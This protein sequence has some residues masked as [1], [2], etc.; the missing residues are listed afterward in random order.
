M[1][2]YPCEF[3]AAILSNSPMGY[4]PP[5]T[6]CVEARRR[7]VGI[8]RPC[9]NES[10]GCFK[11]E[12]KT[13]RVSLRQVKGMQE[14]TLGRIL[15]EREKRLFE[16]LRDFCARVRP[17][18]HVLQNLILAGALDSFSTNRRELLWEVDRDV[19][20]E[21]QRENAPQERFAVTGPLSSLSQAES[22]VA[23]FTPAERI[24][25]EYEVL[26]IN[27]SSHPM[28]YLRKRLDEM[29]IVSSRALGEAKEGQWVK[30]AGYPV[31]PHRPPTKSGKI[32]VFM[33]L[34]DEFG[35]TDITVFENIYQK[36]GQV[37]FQDPCPQLLV[38]GK[39]NKRGNGLSVIAQEV[40]ELRIETR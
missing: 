17:Q 18:K 2:N 23:D 14:G 27:V 9:V 7:E 24:A 8:L 13:I 5:N 6:I 19:A 39:L 31:R 35:M 22:S 15:S 21:I 4:Y 30:V 16:S 40:R 1:R 33:S 3:Y 20:A 32:I 36:C 10:E 25:Y 34:E 37:I 29:G 26:G 38:R 28:A 12:G 11:P